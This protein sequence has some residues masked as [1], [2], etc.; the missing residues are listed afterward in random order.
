[1]VKASPP[2]NVPNA[3]EEKLSLCAILLK[4]VNLQLMW[5]EH[6]YS[7]LL[8][9]WDA[10][11]PKQRSHKCSWGPSGFGG[12]VIWDY[13]SP[14]VPLFNLAQRMCNRGAG[15]IAAAIGPIGAIGR[16]NSQR[17]VSV[18]AVAALLWAIHNHVLQLGFTPSSSL[19]AAASR[20]VFVSRIPKQAVETAETGETAEVARCSKCNEFLPASAFYQHKGRQQGLS[21]YCKK[22]KNRYD[23]EYYHRKKVATSKEQSLG[24]LLLCQSCR[25]ML[26]SADFCRHAGGRNGL[27]SQCKVCRKEYKRR[28]H[29]RYRAANQEHSLHNKLPQPTA[30]ELEAALA[31]E[32]ARARNEALSAWGMHFCPACRQA[33][34]RTDFHQ[35]RAQK[36]G[37][38]RLCKLCS[39]AK[40]N[41]R[42]MGSAS[43]SR[44]S[45]DTPSCSLPYSSASP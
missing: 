6:L 25:Q 15:D 29:A 8:Q 43:A 34:S 10:G 7:D 28:C 16:R 44:V 23:R 37:I 36:Y 33:K 40:R 5:L 18:I 30:T 45:L 27:D 13:L 3:P 35:N 24:G 22:C 11:S 38:A 32:G 26:P 19:L 17:W 2:A 12:E 9:S 4:P 20:I 1:M 21:S 31:L 14:V 41:K 39:S 42:V